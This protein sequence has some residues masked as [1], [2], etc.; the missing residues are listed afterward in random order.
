MLIR[1]LMVRALDVTEQSKM[2]WLVF[3]P[4]EL[5]VQH[6]QLKTLPNGLLDALLLSVMIH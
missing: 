3:M 5:V 2:T 1:L 6:I 4:L